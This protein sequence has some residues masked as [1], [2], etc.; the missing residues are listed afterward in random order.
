MCCQVLCNLMARYSYGGLLIIIADR[1]SSGTDTLPDSID[2]FTRLKEYSVQEE[3][4]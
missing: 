4:L 3:V 1:G 2:A